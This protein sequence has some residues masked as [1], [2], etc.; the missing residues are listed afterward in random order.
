MHSFVIAK[1]PIKH[2]SLFFSTLMGGAIFDPAE[3]DQSK[4]N[5]KA[6]IVIC[7]CNFLGRWRGMIRDV[8]SSPCWPAKQ[9]RPTW[10]GRRSL[11]RR[12]SQS[13]V[14]KKRRE[15]ISENKMN[16][17]L[18]IL[19]LP[20]YTHVCHRPIL[21]LSSTKLCVDA[22]YL[23]WL[24]LTGFINIEGF[25]RPRSLSGDQSFPLSEIPLG[26]QIWPHL[27]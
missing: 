20:F 15:E 7:W 23:L 17:D 19:I 2:W 24:D 16:S 10:V 11:L 13:S 8:L 18:I 5:D 3:E 4:T 21:P 27:G 6:T 22:W 12:S 9:E 26:G 14:C 25:L 1:I